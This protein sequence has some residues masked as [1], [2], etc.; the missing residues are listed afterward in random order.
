MYKTNGMDRY[1]NFSDLERNEKNDEDYAIVHRQRKGK[2]AVVAI[3]G[4]GIEPGTAD[5]ADAVAGNTYTYY[6]FKGLKKKGNTILHLSSNRYD[7]PQIMQVL[8]NAQVVLSI[9][10]CREESEIVFVGGKDSV[11]K[12]TVISSLRSAGFIA[13]VS[14]VP[15]Q[16]GLSD[17]NICNRCKSGKGVQLEISRGLR[18]KMYDDLQRRSLRKRTPLFYS[19]VLC[20][21]TALEAKS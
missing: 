18:K 9:H 4:G 12:E 6:A 13:V 20:L 8:Q 19:F 14:M 5:I 7:E 21:K 16:R 3:H 10:G 17:N 15:G 2:V 1:L 11:L